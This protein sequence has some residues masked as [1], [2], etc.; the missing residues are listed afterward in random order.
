[1]ST[2]KKILINKDSSC[3]SIWFMRQAGRYLPEFKKI[4]SQNQNFINLCLNSDLS[5]EI[6]LQPIQRYNLDS[7]II[8]SDILLI[9]Y[10]LGQEVNFIKEQGPILSNFDIEKFKN[11]NKLNFT[12]KLNSIYK[13]I[14]ITRKNFIKSKP[15]PKPKPKSNKLTKIRIQI[16]NKIK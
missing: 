15:K 1:M 9:P 8:F 13:A 3:Q 4:R 7:A 6:T 14:S 16:K 10:A 5:S 12:K 2:I 11:N